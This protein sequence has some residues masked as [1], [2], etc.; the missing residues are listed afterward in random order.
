MHSTPSM[1][2]KFPP[3]RYEDD[4]RGIQER[5]KLLQMMQ[6]LKKQKGGG[7][8]ECAKVCIA[9]AGG[10][11]QERTQGWEEENEATSRGR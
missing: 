3:R 6:M 1:V 4:G 10:R 8:K 7:K 9:S 11:R 2:E 5:N